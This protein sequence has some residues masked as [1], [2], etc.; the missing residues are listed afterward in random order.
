MVELLIVLGAAALLVRVGQTL[1]AMGLSRSKNSAGA[2]T[3][4]LFDLCAASLAF[5]AVGA[6]I[7]FQRHNDVFALKGSLVLGWR[8]Q[9]GAAGVIFF[10]AA[11]VLIATGVLAGTLAE[12]SRFFPAAGASILLAGLV[13]PMAGNWAWSGW[14]RQLGFVD[15]AGAS[16][17]HLTAGTCALVGAI[18]VGARNGKYHRDGSASMI[19]GH[20]V[21]L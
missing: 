11:A 18:L 6:A 3:R 13:V 12:R 5:W 15:L 1:Y 4:S 14:L 9:P 21:P 7:L 10:H 8:M 17:I 2:A 19:P 16:V 20:N